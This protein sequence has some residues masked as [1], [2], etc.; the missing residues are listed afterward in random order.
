MRV[1]TGTDTHIG[2]LVE[3]AVN[4]VVGC[5]VAVAVLFEEV[6][7]IFLFIIQDRLRC[8]AF[9]IRI[10]TAFSTRLET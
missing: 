7:A 1:V 10:G 8:H 2:T 3:N 6:K 5:G 9:M 4:L